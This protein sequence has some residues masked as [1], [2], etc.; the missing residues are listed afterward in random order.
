MEYY[1]PMRRKKILPFTTTWMVLESS[2]F[3]EISQTKIDIV[4]YPKTVETESRMGSSGRIKW[5][6]V[7][8]R[9]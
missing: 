9:R 3:S 6:K 5:Y 8:T 4:S 7:A 2:M 1:S